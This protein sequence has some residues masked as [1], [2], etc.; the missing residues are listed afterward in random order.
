MPVVHTLS[1]KDGSTH[2]GGVP[3]QFRV[4]ASDEE[5]ADLT[6]TWYY[7]EDVMGIGDT[8]SYS[9]LPPGTLKVT[10]VVSDGTSTTR[11]DIRML[12]VLVSIAALYLHRMR[13]QRQG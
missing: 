1:P 5:G 11:K 13:R 2:Q 6:C 10:V 9:G 3:F 4:N 12:V 7:G 8:I